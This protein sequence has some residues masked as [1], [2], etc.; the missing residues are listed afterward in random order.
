M[1]VCGV[2]TFRSFLTAVM[3][4][5]SFYSRPPLTADHKLLPKPV[6]VGFVVKQMALG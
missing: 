3:K 4:A 1:S 6:P 2:R 5:V